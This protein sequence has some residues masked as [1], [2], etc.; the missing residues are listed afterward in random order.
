VRSFAEHVGVDW[1]LATHQFRRTVAADV[2]NHTLG[3]LIY[4]KHRYKHWP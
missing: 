3:D 2:A 4:L 1:P